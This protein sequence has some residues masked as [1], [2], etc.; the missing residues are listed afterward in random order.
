M[1]FNQQNTATLENLLAA[2][3]SGLSGSQAYGV[4]ADTVAQQQQQTAQRQDK[5]QGYATT[6]LDLAGSGM[7][8]EQSRS[9][10]DLLTPKPGVPQ[11]VENMM[12]TVYPTPEQYAPPTGIN[13][14][15]PIPYAEYSAA[16]DP[17]QIAS[18]VYTQNPAVQ[19]QAF[20]NQL[21][22]QPAPPPAAA[23]TEQRLS[24][25][26]L[27][28]QNYMAQTGATT[29]QAVTFFGSDPEYAGFITQNLTKINTYLNYVT[30][31][32]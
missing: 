19:Q 11:G 32:I 2:M 21:A 30:G 25:V 23:V 22:L 27:A 8:L 12:G 1:N 6:L 3:Q 15:A 28:M 5:M 18:P 20:E 9:I 13:S 17:A 10:M 16:Q 14:S 29:Q 26:V 7:P 31:G 24:D 4:L